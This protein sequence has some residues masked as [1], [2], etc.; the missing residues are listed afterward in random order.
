MEFALAPA[1]D[2]H[3]AHKIQ[4]NFGPG[5]STIKDFNA[6]VTFWSSGKHF[7][8]GGDGGV[9]ICLNRL[10]IE[11]FRPQDSLKYYVDV[12]KGRVEGQGCGMPISDQNMTSDTAF[13]PKCQKHINSMNLVSTL[14]FRG[15]TQELS[16]Y[17][18]EIYRRAFESNAD[19]YCKYDPTDIRYTAMV[20]ELG[21][22]KAH[23]LRG[24]LIY[25]MGRILKDV[26]AG[27]TLE[28][29]FR[30]MFNA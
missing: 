26:S 30:A 17:I 7:H 3:G 1:E 24:L 5:R 2:T 15:T 4:I 18:A 21:S 25:P 10:A 28:G 6:A 12:L 8:G 19:I 9:Y 11:A 27:A 16:G 29:R 22:E 14:F 13:C 23:Q 20:S